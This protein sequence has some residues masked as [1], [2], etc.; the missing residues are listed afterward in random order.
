VL[1]PVSVLDLYVREDFMKKLM[2]IAA[3]GLALVLGG[4]ASQQ[5]SGPNA[6]N[7]AVSH[8][9]G[10]KFGKLGKLGN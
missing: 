7:H 9:S 3:A 5:P 6:G 2:I 4:C 8:Q 1:F 10:G